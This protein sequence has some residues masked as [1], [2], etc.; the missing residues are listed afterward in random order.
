MHTARGYINKAEDLESNV[1]DRPL[2]KKTLQ[3]K[4]DFHDFSLILLKRS[5]SF[6]LMK[7]FLNQGLHGT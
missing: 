4:Q 6:P 2:L 5:F 7:M 3:M 1:H